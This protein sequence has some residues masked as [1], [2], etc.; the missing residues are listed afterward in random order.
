VA[1]KLQK[2]DPVYLN[3]NFLMEQEPIFG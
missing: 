2:V 1:N 3:D